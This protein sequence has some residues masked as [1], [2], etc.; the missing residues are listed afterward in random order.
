MYL[1]L[2]IAL[3]QNKFQLLI[4][5]ILHIRRQAGGD[6]AIFAHGTTICTNS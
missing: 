5:H 6:F 2:D 4:I 3:N 1:F